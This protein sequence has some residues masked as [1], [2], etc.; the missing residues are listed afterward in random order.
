MTVRLIDG[1]AE[2]LKILECYKLEFLLRRSFVECLYASLHCLN[3]LIDLL[4]ELAYLSISFVDLL[5]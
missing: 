4:Y 3:L 2:I 1:I 5:Q